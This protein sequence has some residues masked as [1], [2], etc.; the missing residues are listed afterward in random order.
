MKINGLQIETLK[1]K[2]ARYGLTADGKM[3]LQHVNASMFAVPSVSLNMEEDGE[4]AAEHAAAASILLVDDVPQKPAQD[5]PRVYTM[6][7][8]KRGGIVV[9]FA[10]DGE[11]IRFLTEC[12]KVGCVR[13]NGQSP[14]LLDAKYTD[15]VHYDSFLTYASPSYYA[16]N[17][18]TLIPFSSFN[19]AQPSPLYTAT[20]TE[21]TTV[22]EINAIIDRLRKIRFE[23]RQADMMLEEDRPAKVGEYV[24]I[25]KALSFSGRYSN[26]DI[27]NV[28]EEMGHGCVMAHNSKNEICGLWPEEYRVLP[29]WHPEAAK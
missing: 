18:Y 27:L 13:F 5:K 17:G 26:G 29:N 7:D 24:K 9:T 4:Y 28:Y 10:N 23:R 20:I 2:F 3:N 16:E 11:K 21:Q 14:T 1:G 12:G 15:A 19:F 6:D 25:V 22:A 8:F